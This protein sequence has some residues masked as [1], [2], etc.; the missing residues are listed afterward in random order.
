MKVEIWPQHGPLNSKDIFERFIK[1][2]R[3]SGEEVWVN[4][5]VPNGDVAIIW[6]VLWQ[7][8]MRKYKDIWER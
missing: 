1:S 8:R 2:L 6:S 5:Q 7:G 4:K 3:A